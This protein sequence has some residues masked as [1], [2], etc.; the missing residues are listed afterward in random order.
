MINILNKSQNEGE[1]NDFGYQFYHYLWYL[2]Q[3]LFSMG[4]QR[5]KF[6]VYETDILNCFR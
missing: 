5:N 2:F 6:E 1:I 3:A 4:G